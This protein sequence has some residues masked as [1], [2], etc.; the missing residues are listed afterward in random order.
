MISHFRSDTILPEKWAV[1]RSDS[2]ADSLCVGSG[3]YYHGLDTELNMTHD[4]A[5]PDYTHLPLLGWSHCFRKLV[6]VLS[7]V[8]CGLE[9]KYSHVMHDL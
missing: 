3:T 8:A 5:G 2:C 7:I 4:E 1:Q 9:K 6:P